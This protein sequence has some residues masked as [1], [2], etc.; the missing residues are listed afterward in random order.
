MH[1]EIGIE[2]AQFLLWEYIYP[3]FFAVWQNTE[4]GQYSLASVIP[5]QNKFHVIVTAG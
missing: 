2:A 1:A 4:Q 5:T 3:N